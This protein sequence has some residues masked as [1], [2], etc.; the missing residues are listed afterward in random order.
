MKRIVWE[1]II[2][3]RHQMYRIR[4]ILSKQRKARV[5]KS[6]FICKNVTFI[7]KSFERQKMAKRL[8]KNIQSYYPGVKVIIA[9]DS[10]KPLDLQGENLEVIQ[11]PFNSGLSYGLN[12]ALERVQ[13]PFVIRMDDDELLTPY[14]KFHEQL[15]FL[16]EHPEVDLVGVLA[17]NL[18]RRRPLTGLAETYFKQPMNNAPKKLI[19]P[20]LTKIDDRH[21][22]VGKTP[23]VFIA[24]T[25]KIKQIG[26][27]DN[28]RMIDHNEFF[29]RAAGNIVSVLDT[30]CYVLHTHNPFDSHYQK[31]R[32]D[33]QGDLEY[34]R[35]KQGVTVKKQCN[36]NEKFLEALKTSLQKETISWESIQNHEGQA[37][38][39]LAT[40]QDV[41]PMIY[42]ATRGCKAM[43]PYAAQ[44]RG[45]S[46]KV[47]Q[48]VARQV[49]KTTEFLQLYQRMCAAGAKPLVVKGLVCRDLYPTPDHRPSTDEDVFIQWDDFKACHKE[50][51]K[52]G[53][54]LVEEEQNIV[55]AHEVLYWK[56]DSKLH[57]ELHKELFPPNSET[58]GDFNRFF[59]GVHERAITVNINGVDVYTLNYTDHMMFLICHAFK[60]FWGSGL[61]IRPVCDI[62]LFANEYGQYIDWGYL[63][64]CC[65]E[66]HAEVF[67]A[68][69]F[70]IGEK[71]LTFDEKKACY[72]SEWKTYIKD[73]K[74]LLEDLL[75]AGTLGD[76]DLNRIHSS[77]VTLNAVK[78]DKKGVKAK[79]SLRT[80][81]FPAITDMKKSYQYLD[82]HP[83]LLP[84]AWVSRIA[85]Y[86][87]E[88]RSKR[89]SNPAE[90][91]ALG[92]RRVE[93]LKEYDILK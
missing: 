58:S 29:Y 77:N 52:F 15:Q 28:I 36:I 71:Y 51:V 32:S 5:E 19:M 84:I 18:L 80:A 64:E 4:W 57:I 8:Y 48:I 3:F 11:L 38:F 78:A 22:V 65:K 41:Y 31:Y 82:K 12:R 73:E 68:T 56:D 83:Y 44:L 39:R 93:L 24:R 16:M 1:I 86:G 7:F 54:R 74:A 49:V 35:A 17:Y 81:V 90:S 2:W 46:E 43:E 6:H 9:D 42:E 67:M 72:P 63:L 40:Q 10:S 26:Y 37:L 50:I 88:I 13:T 79:S 34:I 53:M 30:T 21:I 75:D 20:H 70:Q 45:V 60:H 23:N 76:K 25:D 27:D 47:M 61:G 62:M 87:K 85:K 55:E 33:Y 66:I 59:E 89:N 69:L 92:K 14:T 91:L